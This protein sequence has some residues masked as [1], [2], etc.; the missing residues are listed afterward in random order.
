MLIF[1]ALRPPFKK[2]FCGVKISEEGS[3]DCRWA[4]KGL[5]IW[6][7]ITWKL[8]ETTSWSHCGMA[9]N[10]TVLYDTVIFLKLRINEL[11][12]IERKV[13]TTKL[14]Q[15]GSHKWRHT[16][17][18]QN[19]PPSPLCHIK[20]TVSLTTFNWVLHN[21]I[22]PWPTPYLRDVIYE[23]SLRGLAIKRANGWLDWWVFELLTVVNEYLLLFKS[24]LLEYKG[25]CLESANI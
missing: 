21:S 22:P 19:W 13:E 11:N 16:N 3:K 7:L 17:L 8:C 1:C 23:G 20:M 14:Y 12:K 18:T 15:G 5:W 2:L 10:K 24:W 6:P 9:F 25:V 4:W